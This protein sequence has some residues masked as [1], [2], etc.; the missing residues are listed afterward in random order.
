MDGGPPALGGQCLQGG[1]VVVERRQALPALHRQHQVV[2][3]GERDVRRVARVQVGGRPAQ[4]RQRRLELGGLGRPGAGRHARQRGGQAVR[5]LLRQDRD[6]PDERV[7][8][9]LARPVPLGEG[10]RRGDGRVPAE[11]HLRPRAEVPDPVAT[12]DV[13]GLDE[14]RLGVA[15][16]LGD[17][18]PPGVGQPGG[19]QHDPRRVAAPAAVRERRVRQRRGRRGGRGRAGRAVHRH[20]RSGTP[21]RSRAP[22][23]RCGPPGRNA[24]TRLRGAARTQAEPGRGPVRCRH[25][26]ARGCGRVR[27]R[28]GRGPG[29]PTR[30]CCPRS[31]RWRRR[32]RRRR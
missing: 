21:S 11:R 14:G 1:E 19:V 18:Q 13:G 12:R 29:M 24:S 9:Q 6:R 20:L 26:S 7:E 28:A 16:T 3:A 15:E 5:R 27:A 32:T 23:L 31:G 10:D 17:R 8:Q 25:A 30:R 2:R 4:R 22:S